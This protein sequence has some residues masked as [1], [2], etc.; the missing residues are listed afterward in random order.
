M[1]FDR[2][3]DITSELSTNL[4]DSITLPGGFWEWL[5]RPLSERL[6]LRSRQAEAAEPPRAI[7]AVAVGPL[8]LMGGV[9]VPDESIVAMIHLA[10]GRSAK[11]AVI[12]LA[13]DDPVKAAEYGTRLFT[14]FGMKAVQVLE[15]TSRER[16]DNPE[17]AAQLAA[18]DAVF[19]CGDNATLGLEVMRNTASARV[20]RQMMSAGKPIAALGGAAAIT[21]ERVLV[22]RNGQEI[23]AEGLCLAS[24]MLVEP[25]FTQESRFSRVV[26]ALHTPGATALMGVGLDAGAAVAIRDGEGKVLGEAG[27]TFLDARDSMPGPGVAE[28]SFSGL[29][30][31]VLMDGMGINLRTRKPLA[32]SRE[33]AQA[34]GGGR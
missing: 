26:R 31:H 23:L 18:F 2:L 28:G 10:G 1:K 32:Q 12:P 29:Q 5:T 34:V 3:G 13:A 11:L 6:K 16:A 19:L 7:A 21:A 8:V 9:P 24:G 30:V 33:A 25:Q 15:L 22:H 27:V 4:L 17:W 20:L 14:R